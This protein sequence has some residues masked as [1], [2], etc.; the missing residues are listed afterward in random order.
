V[1]DMVPLTDTVSPVLRPDGPAAVEYLRTEQ[2][3]NIARLLVA[4]IAPPI[5]LWLIGFS[6]FGFVEAFKD[7]ALKK[8]T[9]RCTQVI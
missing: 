4:L 8:E 5:A 9:G 1:T 2:V 6:S 7:A 3:V